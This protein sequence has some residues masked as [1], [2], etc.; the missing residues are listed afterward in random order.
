MG[1]CV[2][3]WVP[4]GHVAVCLSTFAMARKQSRMNSDTMEVCVCRV[5]TVVGVKIFSIIQFG[6][7]LL[8]SGVCL[9]LP[10]NR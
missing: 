4:V 3:S 8:T 5:S 10:L 7:F 6:R 1:A 2:C 9:V